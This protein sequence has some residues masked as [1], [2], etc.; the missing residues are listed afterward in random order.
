MTDPFTPELHGMLLRSAGWLPDDMLT[1]ARGLLA[2][3]RCGE[4]A[5]LLMFAGRRTVLPLTEDD[6]DVLVELLEAEGD[7]S[8]SL[9]EIEL[10]PDD[11]VPPWRF[12][13]EWAEPE[14]DEQGEDTNNAMLI[15]ALAEQDLLA[16]AAGEPGLRGLWSAVRSPVDNA[17]Y[18]LPRVVYVAEVDDSHEEAAEPADLTGRLQKSLVAAGERD[19]QVEVIPLGTNDLGYQRAAQRNG[20]LIWAADT[21]SDVKVARV[22]DKSD[23]ETGPAF[24]PDR[25]KIADE[26]ERERLCEYLES[27]TLLLVTAARLD[28]IVEPERGATVPTNFYTDG[29]WVWTDS[30]TYYLREHH[31]APDPELVAHINEIDGPPPL[32]DTVELGR[33]MEALTP[34]EDREPAQTG[35]R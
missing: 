28:D 23:P 16:A 13:A 10:A 34:S 29:S 9:T 30:V 19:P 32:P 20:K 33:V 4:V 25:P 11:A 21:D 26:A 8:G 2:D 3:D 5:R 7:D 17:P 15:S 27:A 6:L 22:F 35:S 14:D 1:H 12:S 24:D 18:P 31:L